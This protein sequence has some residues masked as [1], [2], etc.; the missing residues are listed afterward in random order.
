VLRVL[1][2]A[3]VVSVLGAFAW[4]AMGESAPAPQASDVDRAAEQAR[5]AVRQAL[6]APKG[7]DEMKPALEA[8]PLGQG[9]LLSLPAAPR[10]DRSTESRLALPEPHPWDIERDPKLL[11]MVS[12]SMPEASLRALAIETR[13]VGASLVLRG[14]V[15]DSLPDTLAAIHQLAGKDVATSGFAIDPTLFTRFDVQAVPTYVLLL[16][17]LR[18]C[19]A[20]RCEVPRHLR[21]SG[22]AGLRHVLE[23]MD[24]GAEPEVSGVVA[25]LIA[26]LEDKP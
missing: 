19:T 4:A 10:A 16:E 18:T 13:R 5:S 22:E 3:M 1:I 8:K 12:F 11:V 9:P 24:R 23:T 17:P 25:E 14:L 2:L 21:L 20:E 6:D 7:T 15:N 26:R